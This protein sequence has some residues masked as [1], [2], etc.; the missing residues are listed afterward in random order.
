VLAVFVPLLDGAQVE[1][2]FSLG[3]KTMENRLWFVDRQPPI[4]LTQLQ[5]LADGVAAWHVAEVLPLLSSD[6]ELLSV[7]AEKWDDHVGDIFAQS[8]VNLLGGSATQSHS[9]NVAVKIRFK[10][11][12]A[13]TWRDGSNFVPGI[14]ID[15][16]NLNTVDHTFAEALRFAYVDLIDLASGFGPFPAWRWVITSQVLDGSPRTTQAFA[17]TDFPRVRELPVAQRRKRLPI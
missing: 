7:L 11:S 10:G 14:P 13:Q 6:I 8:H 17:R 3:G 12:T 9:A 16:V 4:T 15:V 5:D 2:G 1:I